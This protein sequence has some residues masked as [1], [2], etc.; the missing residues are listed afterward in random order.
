MAEHSGRLSG[1]DVNRD[2]FVLFDKFPVSK[3]VPA[4]AKALSRI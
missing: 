1:M 3:Y 4:T 2:G